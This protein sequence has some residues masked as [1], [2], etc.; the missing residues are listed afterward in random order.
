MK[1]ARVLVM[2]LAIFTFAAIA[3]CGQAPSSTPL[4]ANQ[5][6]TAADCTAERLG[7]TIPVAAIGE[8][9]SAVTLSQPKWSEATAE[10]PAYCSVDGQMAPIDTSGLTPP[11]KFRV[12]LP[13][14]WSHRALQLG[15][16]GVDG[17]IPGLAGGRMG[18]VFNAVGVGFA[19]YGSDGGHGNEPDWALSDEAMRNLGYM[20][21][22]KAHDAAMTLIERIYG[23]RPRFNY[24]VG[25][26]QGGRE[27]LT[28]VQR[29][30]ADYDGV[31]SGVPIVNFSSL[32]LAPQLIRIQ[33]KPI[34]NWVPATKGNAIA[35]EFVRQ[36]DKLDGLAD[37]LINN[38]AACRAIF[39]V[40][41][42]KP[43]RHPWAAKR[44]PNNVDPN[45]GDDSVN[46]CF[47]DG[48]IATLEFIFSS[49]KF[50]TPLANGV[51]YFGMWAPTT[52]VAG[53]N[54]AHFFQNMP[55]P[56]AGMTPPGG[57]PSGAPPTRG[58]GG[59]PA[60]PGSGRF[61]GSEMQGLLA[62][63]RFRGQEGAAADAPLFA[64]LGS[65]GVIGF[66]MK[67]LGVNS[68]DYVEG[69]K[70]DARRVEISQY[71]DST[72]PD[73]TPFFKHGGK[74]IVTIGS[75]DTTAS[76]G[77]QLDY[78]QSVIDKMGQPNVDSFARFFV[79]P[80]GGHGLSGYSFFIDGNGK[81]VEEKEIPHQ[82]DSF[83]LLR[84]WVEDNKAPAK[85]EVVTGKDGSL[86]LCTYPA[87]PKYVSGDTNL[88]TSYT[89][90]QP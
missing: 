23:A 74:L 21:L 2:T 33:E 17:F 89:C 38:Y 18:P 54:M 60:G 69:G 4:P 14:S 15:G 28:V 83:A 29:Y 71:L 62:S 5:T 70:Y 20:Q 12:V 53:R 32:M 49:Y 45:P 66:L 26:S 24:F 43:N 31:S 6:I 68:L 44:C 48:Q 47:T 8:P 16:G 3:N 88:A 39:N 67:D 58:S 9:V 37:G 87:Y 41:Q 80:E 78:F 50:T 82:I 42:G 10:L 64:H 52:D 56:P 1:H 27:A 22:K 7:T 77:S 36:C 55:K 86:P 72:N 65:L 63:I 46:A 57:M 25:S 61:P 81:K 75:G 40:R 35:A 30:P 84:D 13:A 34:A 51:K 76:P 59:P 79:I 85:S 90:A 11:V 19:T 73:L